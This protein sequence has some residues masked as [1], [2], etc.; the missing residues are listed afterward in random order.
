MLL[1]N[2]ELLKRLAEERL[3]LTRARMAPNT[4]IGYRYAWSM[5]ERWCSKMELAA[6][7]AD[8]ETVSLYITDMISVVHKKVS[9][10]VHRVWAIGRKH[11]EAGIESP[12]SRDVRELLNGARRL[13]IE[14]TRQMKPLRVDQL[15]AMCRALIEAGD[16]LSIRNRAI[17][18]TGFASGLRGASLV[19]LTLE[20]VEF[21][22]Q[23]VLVRVRKEKQD[24][25]GKGRYLGMPRGK[26]T[27]TCPVRSLRDWLE[28]R[29]DEPGALFSR[30]G[31][32]THLQ[33]DTIYVTVKNT[34]RLIGVEPVLYGAHSLRA[35]FITAAG[36]AGVADL[37]IAKQTG[38]RN[39]EVL[40]RYFRSRDAFRANAAGTL[41]L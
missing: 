31:R 20:D 18:V 16:S 10:V 32:R 22:K 35:G 2:E 13:L 8:S 11:R 29:G 41:G 40:R 6:L 26:H 15:Q 7:P 25:E 9:T 34:L 28:I 30:L 14:Q 3:K 12:V 37:V 23:G 39:M 17:L 27:C 21:L 19:A 33:T 5:F 1:S 4:D 36:E 24:Q 38:H